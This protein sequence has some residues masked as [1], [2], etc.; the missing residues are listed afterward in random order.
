MLVHAGRRRAAFPGHRVIFERGCLKKKIEKLAF[1]IEAGKRQVWSLQQIKWNIFSPASLGTPL[2]SR[3]RLERDCIETLND[4]STSK[5]IEC[6]SFS[7]YIF[8]QIPKSA[9]ESRWCVTEEGR[10]ESNFFPPLK[11]FNF[12]YLKSIFCFIKAKEWG[13]A[14][15]VGLPDRCERKKKI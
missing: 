2:Q 11:Y 12:L 1:R 15:E 7:L 14:Q 8:P 10:E 4:M 13:K 5:L 3:L 9:L 6:I